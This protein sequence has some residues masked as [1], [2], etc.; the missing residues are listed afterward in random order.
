MCSS[1]RLY[2]KV[3][4]LAASLKDLFVSPAKRVCGLDVVLGKLEWRCGV[5]KIY[6]THVMV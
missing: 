3:S 2:E 6:K 5:R 1:I 4:R